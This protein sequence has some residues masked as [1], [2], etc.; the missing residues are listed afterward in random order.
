MIRLPSVDERNILFLITFWRVRAIC[1]ILHN[2][3]DYLSA[4][5]SE[6]GGWE[7]VCL[8]DWIFNVCSS[9]KQSVLLFACV[10]H[11]LLVYYLHKNYYYCYCYESNNTLRVSKRNDLDKLC[12]CVIVYAY[13][14]NFLIDC[15]HYWPPS[16]PANMQNTILFRRVACMKREMICGG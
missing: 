1:N 5:G 3:C 8:N 10:P 16:F 9:Y 11:K 2:E 13:N 7:A 14:D 6:S 4:D 15:D 12:G